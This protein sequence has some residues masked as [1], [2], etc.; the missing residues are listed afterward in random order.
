M[1]DKIRD[2]MFHYNPIS[3]TDKEGR[4]RLVHPYCFIKGKDSVLLHCYQVSGYSSSPNPSGWRNLRVS[5]F[6]L[7]QVMPERFNVRPDFKMPKEVN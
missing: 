2:A 3:V 7:V 5:D 1:M 6:A 4:V